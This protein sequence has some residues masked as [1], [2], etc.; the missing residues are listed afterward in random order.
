[1][2][3][4]DYIVRRNRHWY[5][6]TR[7][8]QMVH[9]DKIEGYIERTKDMPAKVKPK[10]AKIKKA[11][12]VKAKK[13]KVVKVIPAFAPP[14]ITEVPILPAEHCGKPME[15]VGKMYV[16]DCGHYETSVARRAIIDF[17]AKW[18]ERR[19]KR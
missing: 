16:C 8:D 12:V 9:P 2:E 11:P 10:P 6:D 5:Y 1:M 3:I 4:P 19:K 18:Y 14:I 17:S 7:R 13:V 15:E